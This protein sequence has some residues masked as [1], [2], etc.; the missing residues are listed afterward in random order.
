MKTQKRQILK[1]GMLAAACAAM[2][3]CAGAHARAMEGERSSAR[4]RVL[5]VEA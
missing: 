4:A 2:F 1:A 3:C 5:I